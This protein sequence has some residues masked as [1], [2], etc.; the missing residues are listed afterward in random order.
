MSFPIRKFNAS[1]LVPGHTYRV[2]N[3]FKDYDGITH[4]AG[5]T[6]RFVL[7]NFL[8][9]EDGLTLF[10]ERDQQKMSFRLQWRPESQGPLIDNFSNF[11]TEI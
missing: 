4:A 6:W 3:A 7:K 11:V 10:I 1:E 5:E 9:Y 8:A 2:F